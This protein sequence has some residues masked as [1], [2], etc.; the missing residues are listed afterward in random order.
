MC[1]FPKGVL[2]RIMSPT[3]R[4]ALVGSSITVNGSIR[5]GRV[6]YWVKSH[7]KTISASFV[8]FSDAMGRDWRS[9]LW[10]FQGA[11]SRPGG[12]CPR[13]LCCDF[14]RSDF[15]ILLC[16]LQHMVRWK[17]RISECPNRNLPWEMSCSRV[18]RG[19]WGS[20]ERGKRFTKQAG[21]C[22]YLATL[23]KYNVN[24]DKFNLLLR[25]EA[26]FLEYLV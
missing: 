7:P 11:L 21:D 8:P 4:Y 15:P 19:S 5:E 6:D 20:G 1:V 12:S 17:N 25:S 14:F 3:C 24:D 23:V 10:I 26:E 2:S 18:L 16:N 13:S 22:H 9:R